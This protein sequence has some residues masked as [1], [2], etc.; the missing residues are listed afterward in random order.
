MESGKSLPGQNPIDKERSEGE[1]N[2]VLVQS[3]G[4]NTDGVVSTVVQLSFNNR[5]TCRGL[6]GWLPTKLSP[7][8][9]FGTSDV[10]IQWQCLVWPQAGTA[11]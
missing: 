5:P 2:I 6:C 8:L 4:T 10:H 11:E 9:P 1:G 3:G 7:P